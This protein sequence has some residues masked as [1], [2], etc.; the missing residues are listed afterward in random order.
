M[1]LFMKSWWQKSSKNRSGRRGSTSEQW[2]QFLV[3]FHQTKMSKW[4][5]ANS[6]GVGLSTL[7][8]WLRVER[9]A[10]LCFPGNIETS[11][12]FTAY[13]S[14]PGRERE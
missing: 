12:A 9:E 3:D 8:Q 7:V 11:F 5:F 10:D 4:N 2:Q 13:R 1:S 14:K 6:N